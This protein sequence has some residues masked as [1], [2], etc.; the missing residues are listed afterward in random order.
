DRDMLAATVATVAAGGLLVAVILTFSD[1]RI[2]AVELA[3]AKQAAALAR[4]D[5][6]TGLPNRRHLLEALSKRLTTL[7][8]DEKLAVIPVHLDRFK[9]VND[10]Y[11]HAVGD[12]LLIKIA[13]MLSDESA[14]EGFVARLGGDE[15][16]L[17]IPYDSIDTLIPRLSALVARFD[18]PIQL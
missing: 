6:L 11:G 3:A 7:P 16:I 15:F 9:P 1:R 17:L 4:H 8:H 14:D 13:S 12:E 10:L 18:A 2:A 5:A